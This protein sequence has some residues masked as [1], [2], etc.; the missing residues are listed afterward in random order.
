MGA[1]PGLAGE[2]RIMGDT[3]K[4]PDDDDTAS[5]L[6]KT[7]WRRV[8]ALRAGI[9]KQAG[10]LTY[11]PEVFLSE[12]THLLDELIK[13]IA[14][15]YSMKHGLSRQG[16]CLT[17]IGGYGRR[18]MAPY[19][20][21]DIMVLN[22]GRPVDEIEL[23]VKDLTYPLWDLGLEVG[24][25]VRTI[26]ECKH[27][28]RQDITIY[29]ALVDSRY[30]WGDGI[31]YNRYKAEVFGKAL[32]LHAD[33]SF[34]DLR[35]ATEKR[36]ERYGRSV[37][38]LEPNVKEGKGGLRDF[39]VLRWL[40]W[41]FD[42]AP[43][44]RG[45]VSGDMIPGRLSEDLQDALRFLWKVRLVL[46]MLVR[47]K[48][49]R[50]TFQ[51]Q[52]EI[53]LHL[54]YR[55]KGH[56]L[57]V[58]VFM[59]DYYEKATAISR[60]MALAFEKLSWKNKARGFSKLFPVSRRVSRDFVLR[61]GKLE[62]VS[63]GVFAE[64]PA[65]MIRAFQ[66]AS[67]Y[68]VD[69]GWQTREYITDAMESNPKGIRDDAAA[70]IAFLEIFKKGR[71]IADT[72]IQMN[73][74]KLLGYLLPEFE[75]IYC[76]VQHDA[77]HVYTV[78]VHS[79]F[80]VAEIEKLKDIRQGGADPLLRKISG[81]IKQ[82]FLLFLAAFLHDIGKGSGKG[83]AALGAKIV[84]SMSKR[85][86]LLEAQKNLLV[87]LVENHLMMS[88]ISQRRDLFEEKL[89]VTLANRIGAVENLKML[90]IL[91]Y[92][93][94]RS[95]GKEAW[96]EW[97]GH[98]LRELFFKVLYVLE[99]GKGGEK[100]AA[101][102][103][104]QRLSEV[105]FRIQKR[106]DPEGRLQKLLDSLPYRYLL[107]MT[108]DRIER[109]L[110][111]L[112]SQLENPVVCDIEEDLQKGV[113]EIVVVTRDRHGLFSLI[114]GVMA[115]N[116]INILSADIHTTTR[117]C[118]ID[119]FRVNSPFEPSLKRSGIWD[120]FRRDLQGVLSG[121]IKLDKLVAR[122]RGMVPARRRKIRIQPPEVQI[123]NETSYFYTILDVFAMDRVGLLYDMTRVFSELELDISLA[124]ISTK[125]DRVADVFYV[126][127]EA[128][129]KI[130]D[131]RKLDEIRARLEQTLKTQKP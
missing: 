83:H 31:L 105:K 4:K 92:A 14:D 125:V 60:A 43:D 110:A 72:L 17:A 28:I 21:V 27:L 8:E 39:H 127:D 84:R 40:L 48:N 121:E 35:K 70:L 85:F 118:A 80:T 10:S 78:D 94:I 3:S 1:M 57:D 124:K 32:R 120:E 129:E 99:K 108:P 33:K 62:T 106:G 51:F 74:I 117:H 66:I 90:Y 5:E 111:L 131:H 112:E 55:Q 98:L 13:E 18:E 58:E 56:T 2:A 68:G 7:R 75:N 130:I 101:R 76:R 119:L 34:F 6:I 77:Y 122:Q 23:F 123:D 45:R 71:R 59:R 47:R 67:R 93:D 73:R 42:G 50:L 19:S 104:D 126:Q 54:G 116:Q 20:D 38:L 64:T 15:T 36:H 96:N 115:A 128:G 24:Y 95:V 22:Q 103:M 100:E 109:H 102:L 44:S 81:E 11:D 25:S 16:F 69:V 12:H 86:G 79:I 88:E 113:S 89:I 65:M 87:F 52:E 97:K 41:P 53:A 63:R 30:L 9:L 37:F 82:P 114:A 49:D 107:Q 46:H 61:H 29:T 26:P 91:T